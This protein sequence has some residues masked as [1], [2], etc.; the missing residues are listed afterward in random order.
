MGSAA[1]GRGAGSAGAGGG[2]QAADAIAAARIA[3]RLTH[4]GAGATRIMR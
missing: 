1:D 3:P 2:P 4:F